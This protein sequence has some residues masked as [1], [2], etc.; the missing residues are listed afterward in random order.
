V[1]A[2]IRTHCPYGRSVRKIECANHKVRCFTSNLHRLAS[3][4][5]LNVA[6]RKIL[7]ARIPRLSRGAR[8]AIR[9]CHE[10]KESAS[11][12]RYDFEN[13]PYHVFGDHGKCRTYIQAHCKDEE[14]FVPMLKE[15]GMFQ[16]IGNVLKSLI[17]NAYTLILNLTSN[18]AENVFSLTAK[19]I[20][21]KRVDYTRS[22]QFETR[23]TAAFLNFQKGSTWV[24]SPFK[25]HCGNSPGRIFRRNVEQKDRKRK[26][27]A[28][29]IFRKEIC[30]KPRLSLQAD[31]NYGA[32]AETTDEDNRSDTMSS[33]PDMDLIQ[34]EQECHRNLSSLQVL[35]CICFF[36]VC[37]RGALQ[38]ITY[39]T[40][41]NIIAHDAIL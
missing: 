30:K 38:F 7:K 31:C 32:V 37:V 9:Y 23:V 18:K 41:R 28:E 11:D 25:K 3:N 10:N 33:T 12:L 14:N 22:D 35:M 20:N 1:F 8:S 26:A 16:E 19:T 34:L 24:V 5:S 40:I 39:P 2:Q 15:Q 6:S 13:L 17:N 36:N 21:G 4:T 29:R 27:N